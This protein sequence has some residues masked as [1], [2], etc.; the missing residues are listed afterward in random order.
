MTYQKLGLLVTASSLLLAGC[1]TPAPPL[2]ASEEETRSDLSSSNYQPAPREI[3]DNIGTQEVLAQ[4]AFWS[5]EYNLNPTDLE[6]AIKFA[7]VLRKIGNPSRAVEVTQTTRAI[8]PRN[9]YLNAEYAASLLADQKT[10]TAL[11]V[12]DSSL[13]DTPAYGRLWSLKGVALDQMEK[14]VE[15]RPFYD[16]A[17]QITPNDPNVMANLGLNY[18][19]SGDPHTA[20]TWLSRAAALPNASENV[21]VNLELV[22]ALVAEAEPQ[23]LAL[24]Q[25]YQPDAQASISQSQAPAPQS[26]DPRAPRQYGAYAAGAQT[27]PVPSYGPSYGPNLRKGAS[28]PA[29]QSAPSSGYN[30]AAQAPAAKP[31]PTSQDV[32]ERIANNVKLKPAP[33]RVPRGYQQPPAQQ[34]QW[35]GQRPAQGQTQGQA[36]GQAQ[37]YQRQAPPQQAY[38]GQGQPTYQGQPHQVAAAQNYAGQNYPP[39]YRGNPNAAPQ[40]YP[41]QNQYPYQGGANPAAQYQHPN[42]QIRGG[43]PAPQTPYY[44]PPQGQPQG[45]VQGQYQEQAQTLQQRRIPARRRG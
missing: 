28:G 30:R 37:G 32:L 35:Q 26:T 44:Y 24:R 45:Q 16:R 15:A 13:K 12:I 6:A 34:G 38:Q 19:L 18:A 10:R 11:K 21:F 22:E 7:A 2:T 14:Y 42:P 41:P 36:Q 43:Y 20:K 3:R 5:H 31:A 39:Q 8:Y 4:A 25:N 27:S 40:N 29:S 33:K 1:L 23:S 17:L 9:P